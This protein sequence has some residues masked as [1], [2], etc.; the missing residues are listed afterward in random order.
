MAEKLTRS[1]LNVLKRLDAADDGSWTPGMMLPNGHGHC[2]GRHF[3][4]HD[5]LRAMQEAALIEY[6]KAPLH[7][8]YGYRITTKGRAA[9]ALSS[10]DEI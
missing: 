1:F 10:K 4:K 7:S 2:T 8:L 3:A 6:G 5:T 9:L